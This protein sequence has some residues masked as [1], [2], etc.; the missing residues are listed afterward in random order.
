MDWNDLEP[1]AANI[2]NKINTDNFEPEMIYAP[3]IYAGLIATFISKNLSNNIPIFVGV[4]EWRASGEFRGKLTDDHFSTERWRISIPGAILENYNLRVLIVN[5]W[6][7]SGDGLEKIVEILTENK[8]DRARIKSATL[9]ATSVAIKNNKAPDYY[10][11]KTE[12]PTFSFP[13]GLA[14]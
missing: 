3:S 5:D 12:K 14:R 7:M 10:W 1:A 8:F 2:A 13:W 9:I 11:K 6:V 4:A